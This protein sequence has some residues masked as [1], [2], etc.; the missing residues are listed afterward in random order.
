MDALSHWYQVYSSQSLATLY[1]LMVFAS[2]S[3]CLISS[4]IRL[5]KEIFHVVLPKA[6]LICLLPLHSQWAASLQFCSKF[7]TACVAVL[8][9]FP[10]LLVAVTSL[11]Y[12]EAEPF[13]FA[14]AV[15]STNT[16]G[17]TKHPPCQLLFELQF[18]FRPAFSLLPSANW[19]SLVFAFPLLVGSDDLP[20]QNR[21]A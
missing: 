14:L 10:L 11:Q 4:I 6:K 3:H 19:D 13:W 1:V 5:F 2:Q 9:L 16:S 20:F 8:L 17:C 12:S 15:S 7:F 21:E 18:S